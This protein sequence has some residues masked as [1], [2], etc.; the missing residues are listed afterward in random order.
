LL[1]IGLKISGAIEARADKA[2]S[3]RTGARVELSWGV[4]AEGRVQGPEDGLLFPRLSGMIRRKQTPRLEPYVIKVM[5]PIE[6]TETAR[7]QFARAYHLTQ[8]ILGYPTEAIR[9]LALIHDGRIKASDI[10]C[11]H[12][13][14]VAPVACSAGCSMCCYQHVSISGSEACIIA[15]YLRA[16]NPNHS[17]IAKHAKRVGSI[18]PQDQYTR[19]IACPF[20]VN[21]FCSIYAARPLICRSHLSLSLAKCRL[22]WKTRKSRQQISIPFIADTGL[23][24]TQ[25]K[26]GSDLAMAH[27][28]WQLACGELAAMV[29]QA[30]QPNAVEAWLNG[31]CLFPEN[32]ETQRYQSFADEVFHVASTGGY[33]AAEAN[34]D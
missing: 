22:S 10:M 17:D 33:L 9:K 6:Y 18:P 1:P 7:K 20:L 26:A 34:L 32:K 27:H 30:A 11:N 8:T 25:L 5:F 2:L 28:G 4:D 16:E 21:H 15:L 19:G 29:E 24:T 12:A 14:T 13:K 3:D 31:E 23:A